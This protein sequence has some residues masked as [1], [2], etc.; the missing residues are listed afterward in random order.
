MSAPILWIVLPMIFSGGLLLIVRWRRTSA[1]VG[2]ALALFLAVSALLLPVG[3]SIS[4]G[5]LTFEMQQSWLLFG[6]RFILENADRPFVVIVNLSIAFWLIGSQ[7]TKVHSLLIP[8]GMASGALLIASVLVQPFYYGAISLLIA[9]MLIVILFVSEAEEVTLGIKRY[10]IFQGLAMPLLLLAGWLMSGTEASAGEIPA[11]AL[12]YTLLL[13]GFSLLLSGVPFQSWLPAVAQRVNLYSFSFA[14]FIT[15]FSTLLFVLIFLRQTAWLFTSSWMI[16]F[17]SF[18][19]LLMTFLG[20]L[21][22][23]YH[24]HLGRWMGYAVVK[25][26]GLSFLTVSL[27]LTSSQPL[28]FLAILF[29]QILPRGIALA[30]LGLALNIFHDHGNSLRIQDLLGMGRR[31]PFATL[32]FFVAALTLVGFPL[33][34]AF[35]IHLLVWQGW[36]QRFPPIAFIAIFG[37][38][39]VL[40]G[41]LRAMAVF[42]R[43]VDTQEAIGVEFESRY[44]VILLM[45]SSFLLLFTGIFPQ[46]SLSTLYNLGLTFLR[47]G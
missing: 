39:G 34:A 10:W 1:W 38:V 35:P 30:L 28:S 43:N 19:G 12:I 7:H 15:S 6:R 4:L 18:Q 42:V 46:W 36:F 9:A 26:I 47:G 3:K 21:G 22:A 24:H 17:F 32:A 16:L 44:Q 11:A 41:G 37:S 20:G 13:I 33:T 25:E 5:I 45:L 31:Y 8:V 2:S 40:I 29:M 27:G 23:I 14:V